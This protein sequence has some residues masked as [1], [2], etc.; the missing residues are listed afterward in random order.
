MGI[1]EEEVLIKG[2]FKERWPAQSRRELDC[3]KLI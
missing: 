2:F 1:G 3:G